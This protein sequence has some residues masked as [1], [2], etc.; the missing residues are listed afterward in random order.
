[1]TSPSTIADTQTATAPRSEAAHMRASVERNVGEGN[2]P[3]SGINAVHNFTAAIWTRCMELGIID[4][5]KSTK[6]PGF[7]RLDTVP[8][9]EAYLPNGNVI[10]VK[11]LTYNSASSLGGHSG[12]IEITNPRGTK[13][14]ISLENGVVY[15]ARVDGKESITGDGEKETLALIKVAD[16]LAIQ[17]LAL[18]RD[19][20]VTDS[21]T[22]MARKLEDF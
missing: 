21:A 3:G 17:Y 6:L 13:I 12:T 8:D 9:H 15:G 2:I 14:N 4:T 20:I 10:S 18:D 7:G 22:R 11:G 16:K 1:M 5:S 19:S